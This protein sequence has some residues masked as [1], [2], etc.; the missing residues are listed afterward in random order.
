MK[1]NCNKCIHYFITFDPKAPKG[2]RK[3]Q[4]KS[5]QLPSVIVKQ[6]NHGQECMGHSP[7]PSRDKEKNLNDSR[8]W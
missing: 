5:S 2:C 7:K 6:A 4:I 8:Y 1:P 3:F